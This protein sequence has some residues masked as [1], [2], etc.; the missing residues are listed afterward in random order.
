MLLPA[1]LR[2][3]F[4]DAKIGFFLHTAFPSSEIYRCVCEKITRVR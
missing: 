3:R 2:E 4:P 1:M